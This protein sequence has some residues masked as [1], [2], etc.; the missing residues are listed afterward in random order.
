MVSPMDSKILQA[1]RPRTVFRPSPIQEEHSEEDLPT[2]ENRSRDFSPNI[3]T[4]EF[5]QNELANAFDII[6]HT[7]VSTS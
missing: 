7:W 1:A 6:E 3:I 5:I 2:P 4:E